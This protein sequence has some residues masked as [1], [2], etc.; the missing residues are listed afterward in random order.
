M[1]PKPGNQRHEG[2]IT[3]GKGLKK[4]MDSA[5]RTKQKTILS[6]PFVYRWASISQTEAETTLSHLEQLLAP[7]SVAKRAAAA[8]RTAANEVARD[9]RIQKTQESEIAAA[10]SELES[11]KNVDKSLLSIDAKLRL[12]ADLK[13]VELK[14]KRLESSVASKKRRLDLDEEDEEEGVKEHPLARETKDSL[15]IG[16]NSLTKEL[17]NPTTKIR[18][19]FV[20]KSDVPVPHL[21]AHLPTL[22]HLHSIPVLLVPLHIGAESR[23]AQALG[24]KSVIALGIKQDSPLFDSLF[25]HVRGFIQPVNLPWLPKE[26]KKGGNQKDG[27]GDES[28]DGNDA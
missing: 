11:L 22:C 17:Q 6:S 2:K 16:I 5:T 25:E 18:A 14:R 20:C 19:I 4:E 3:A 24:V 27:D 23:I 26:A 15:V 1:P 8:K 10:K 21:Y 7:I 13:R 28:M 12:D 9:L